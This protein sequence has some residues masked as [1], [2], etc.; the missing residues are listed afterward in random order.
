MLQACITVMMGL[1]KYHVD[2]VNLQNTASTA[3]FPHPQPPKLLGC[4]NYCIDRCDLNIV[5]VDGSGNW[6]IPEE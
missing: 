6:E 1:T 4:A 2:R 5:N 3:Y